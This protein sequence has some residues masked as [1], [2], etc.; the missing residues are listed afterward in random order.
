M[1]QVN[2]Y[3]VSERQRAKEISRAQDESDLRNGRVSREELR[4]ANGVLSSLDI[5]ASSVRRRSGVG[6]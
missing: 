4:S 1:S 3:S 5:A 6:R 2:R